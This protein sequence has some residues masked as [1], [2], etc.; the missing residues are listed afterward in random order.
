[1]QIDSLMAME[2]QTKKRAAGEIKEPRATKAR[3]LGNTQEALLKTSL[4]VAAKEGKTG[5]IKR[6]IKNAREE[7]VSLANLL[8]LRD[9]KGKTPLYWAIQSDTI[10]VV[11]EL[12]AIPELDVRQRMIKSDGIE[13]PIFFCAT[14]RRMLETL[15][16][17]PALPIDM[18]DT[19]GKTILRYLEPGTTRIAAFERDRMRAYVKEKAPLLM[20]ADVWE[21][22]H[23]EILHT[24]SQL[25]D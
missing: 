16:D 14:S 15:L 20:W 6:I 10:A 18:T 22:L 4:C 1:M 12:L 5:L 13:V 9:R 3:A 24:N 19:M 21:T 11:K 23:L 2:Q 8:N 17:H 25:R 7:N